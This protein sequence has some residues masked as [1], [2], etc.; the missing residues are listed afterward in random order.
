ME[1]VVFLINIGTC[2]NGSLPFCTGHSECTA[3]HL[4]LLTF[5]FS[6]SFDSCGF[7][8]IDDVANLCFPNWTAKYSYIF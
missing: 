7:Y 3:K 4:F 1:E 8:S 5:H 6:N 2:I